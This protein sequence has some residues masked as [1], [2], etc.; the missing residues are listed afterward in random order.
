LHWFQSFTGKLGSALMLYGGWGLIAISFLDSSFLP[1]PGFNDLALIIAAG[2]RPARAAWYALQ[3]TLGSVLG[4]YLIYSLAQGGSRLFWWKS[5]P[6]AVARATGWLERNDFVALL[7]ASLLPPPAP[8]KA[9]VLTAGVV[10]INAVRFIV[11]LLLGRGLRFGTE[12]WL[13]TR[14]G[15]QAGTYLRHRLGWASL[16]A[17][18]VVVGVT[19]LLRML[20]RR[21]AK[22]SAVLGPPDLDVT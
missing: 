4:S 8:L 11:A 22:P 2:T 1:L 15:P 18:A 5:T 13:A 21:R 6:R 12:A 16:L 14:Y 3:S 20:G 7:V 17:V 9:F 19:L 10:R